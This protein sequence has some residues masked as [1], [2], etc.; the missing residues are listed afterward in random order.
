[1]QGTVKNFNTARGFG[2]I[3]SG[4]Q[5]YFVHHTNILG[6]TG[7]R[8]LNVGDSVEFDLGENERGPQAVNVLVV[9][10]G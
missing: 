1:M 3:V 6:Q 2:F 10:Q 4:G 5:D 8:N 9:S 7:R